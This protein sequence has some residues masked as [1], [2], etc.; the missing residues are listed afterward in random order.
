MD[1]SKRDIDHNDTPEK[2]LPIA[3]H[4]TT[5]SQR[6]FDHDDAPEKNVPITVHDM[7]AEDRAYELKRALEV[8]PGIPV[9]SWRFLQMTGVMLIV[10]MCGGD[11]GKSSSTPRIGGQG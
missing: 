8:D 3:V 9:R 11:A 1:Q 10:C 2:D 7:S 5:V 4:G 6:D